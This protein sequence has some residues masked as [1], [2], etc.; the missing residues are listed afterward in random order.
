M[1]FH[2]AFFAS[3]ML[4]CILLLFTAQGVA[5]ADESP[6]TPF[7]VPDDM[8]DVQTN[9]DGGFFL[10][11]ESQL[12]YYPSWTAEP[13]SLPLPDAG[14]R[15]IAMTPDD[16]LVGL[17]QDAHTIWGWEEEQWRIL[18]VIPPEHPV[19]DVDLTYPVL[20]LVH[21]LIAY[22][23]CVLL[24]FFSR[25][26]KQAKT[27]LFVFDTMKCEEIS[28]QE[29]TL[30]CLY[31]EDILLTATVNGV[32]GMYQYDPITRESHRLSISGLPAFPASVAYHVASG[33]LYA[34]DYNSIFAASM[35]EPVRHVLTAGGV[36]A[37]RALSSTSLLI[38]NASN[39][40]YHCDTLRV[41]SAPVLRTFGLDYVDASAFFAQTGVRVMEATSDSIAPFEHFANAAPSRDGSIDVYGFLTRDGLGIIKE[42]G[43]YVDL[44]TSELLSD[45]SLAL[46][47]RI[48]EA[49]EYEGELAAWPLVIQAIVREDLIDFDRTFGIPSPDTFEDIIDMASSVMDTEIMH[50]PN[51]TMFLIESYSQAEML[52]Y[53]LSLY[54]WQKQ[55]LHEPLRFN[56]QTCIRILDRI[57]TE[58]PV[59]PPETVPQGEGDPCLI[60]LTNI[61]LPYRAGYSFPLRADAQGSYAIETL[62]YVAVINPYSPNIDN[63][64]AFLEYLSSCQNNS[65]HPLYTTAVPL[66]DQ[67]TDERIEALQGMINALIQEFD[68]GE[69]TAAAKDQLEELERAIAALQKNF[70]EGN[71]HDLESFTEMADFL[72]ISQGDSV[73]FDEGI[74]N[75]MDQLLAGRITATE[76]AE[77]C[78]QRIDMIYEEQMLWP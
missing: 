16:M 11:C 50:S 8:V 76:F 26:S 35:G 40:V 9:S 74:R 21:P 14:L 27:I 41:D 63:A 15:L 33:S 24:T 75:F 54:I 19:Y 43:F 70:Y 72:C 17:G 44:Y 39:D 10:L 7:P 34:S 66:H 4:S 42:K 69:L 65:S 38:I 60:I 5:L 37:V 49:V 3:V 55:L 31:E 52:E 73:L 62:C 64:L 58:I 20:P 57:L 47:P 51:A 2:K 36:R 22:R 29:A 78:D 30:L 53:Y 18:A 59:D 32:P 48:L 77:K 28:Y 68:G 45:Q 12:L 25:E 13:V 71:I 6:L 56:T 67:E 46:Y 1:C 61:P 23:N